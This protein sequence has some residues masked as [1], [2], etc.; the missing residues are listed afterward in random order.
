MLKGKETPRIYT[1]SKRRL[2]PDTTL[3]FD[4]V[5]FAKNVLGVELLPWQEWLLIHAFEIEGEFPD[6]WRFRFRTIVVLVGRQ[7]GKTTL[8]M[9]IS[10][11]FLYVLGVALILGTAQDVST[12]EDT[13]QA[14]VDMAQSDPDL[15]A[16][17][18]HVWQTNGAKRL[19]L[20]RRR[21]YRVRASTRR[22]GRGRSADLVLM[23]EIREHT[24]FKAWAALSKTGMARDSS[25]I[26]CLSNAGDG[27]SVLL[28]HLR[29][30]AHMQLGDP[31]NLEKTQ[32]A[33]LGA[34]V[35]DLDDDTLAIFEWS[36]APDA[37]ITDP[38]AWAQ[39]NPS[40]GYYITERAIKS[41]LSTDTE[42]DF[43]TEV[44]CQ[45]VTAAIAPPFP[46]GAWEAGKD[47]QSEIAETSPLYFGMDISHDRSVTSIA[48]CGKRADGAW[49][50]ELIANRAGIGWT[51]D[52]L[53]ERAMK[54]Q[55]AIAMQGRGAPVSSMIDV[56][57]AIDGVEVYPCEGRDLTGYCGR[58]WDAVSVLDPERTEPATIDPIYH[59]TQAALDLAANIAVTKPLGDGAWAWDRAKSLEDISPLVAATMAYGLAT[60]TK[61]ATKKYASV[62]AADNS[63]GVFVI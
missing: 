37:E 12:A 23:D 50:I 45:W 35:E 55:I 56:Y 47:E 13:W 40:L 25:I 2:T 33:S 10:L 16:E 21:E 38:E 7:N 43:R 48:V 34:G 4:M 51:I 36:A 46:V 60:R 44:L 58:L 14:V 61:E 42:T 54:N 19:S 20:T 49:H 5:E 62:Y 57:A 26:L 29:T 18:E 17:I 28:R 11:Y 22:A 63:P 3:G 31:D 8:G 15:A 59:R 30:R 53:Q 27:S 41:A 9:V 32:G 39:A 24:D 1:K 6:K 52:W